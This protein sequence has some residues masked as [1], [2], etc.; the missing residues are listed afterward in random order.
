MSSAFHMNKQSNKIGQ[1]MKEKEMNCKPK[2]PLLNPSRKY[3]DI[4]QD[5]ALL[6]ENKLWTC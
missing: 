2:G 1:V 4:K 5:T 3:A 6:T